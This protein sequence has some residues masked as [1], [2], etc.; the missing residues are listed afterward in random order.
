M[1]FFNINFAMFLLQVIIMKLL[2]VTNIPS[3]YRRYKFETL[4]KLLNERGHQLEVYFMAKTEPTRQWDSDENMIGFT[5]RIFYNFNLWRGKPIMHF[6]PGLL[7][8]VF[9]SN[10]DIVVVGGYASPSHI[11]SIFFTKREKLV[12]SIESNISS[13]K[14]D[15][16]LIKLIRKY[17]FSKPRVFQVTGEKTI[18]YLR[19]HKV[20]STIPIIK[21]PN[22]INQSN[23]PAS[24]IN[25]S[26][27]T[28]KIKLFCVA[29]FVQVKGILP[30]IKSI[31]DDNKERFEFIFAGDGELLKEAVKFVND[32]NLSARFLGHINENEVNSYLNFCDAFLLPSISD[33]SPL[34][35]I[36][37][38]S[39]GKPLLLSNRVGNISEV[40]VE[41]SNGFSFDI[42]DS[43]SINLSLNNL[44]QIINNGRVG[45]FES[46]SRSLFENNF[47]AYKVLNT[48]IDDL[49]EIFSFK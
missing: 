20:S 23:F 14:Y 44:Y 32:N 2:I 48:Y 18:E 28:Q 7:W 15:N 24:S 5:S 4:E 27:T 45:S 3:P 11:L 19:Y 40:L 46:F 37:A 12:L 42:F 36:E 16:W 41:G 9:R 17:A 10:C 30:F 47:E 33:A 38:L 29:R 26:D 25:D 34:S 49:E 31:D 21:L 1:L 13:M 8:K 22:V 43:N 35:A 39:Q 6:N